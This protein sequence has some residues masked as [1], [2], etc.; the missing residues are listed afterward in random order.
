MRALALAL[1]LS[2]FSGPA[3]AQTCGG[4]FPAF[5]DQMR[6]EAR[7]RGHDQTTVDRF[8]RNVRRDPDV[9]AADKRQGHFQRDFIDFSGRLIAQY[10]VDN[11][12]YYANQLD[13][14]FDRIEARYGVS[15]GV[16]LAFWAFETDFG[17]VQ[18]DYNTRDA[19]VT[20][21]HDCR[22][23]E[24]FRPHVF[25]ALELFARG[26]FDP[27]NT[28]GAWAGEIGQVQ[29]LPE[30][31]LTN[32]VDGD[33]DGRV[34][35][36]TSSADALMSGAAMLSDLGWRPDEPWLQ[37]IRVPDTLDW[38]LTGLDQPR[39][40]SDWA[41]MGVT[42]RA[43]NLRGDLDAAVLLPMGRNGPAF[44]AYPNF[45]VYFEWN[46]SFVYVLTAA[47]FANILEGAPR[48]DPR[49]PEPGLS[50]PDI[51]ALQEKLVARGYDVGGIDGIIG[52]MTRDAVQEEQI[53]LGMPADAW[54]TSALL[55]AL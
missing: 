43:G 22:R 34:T 48:F 13:S 27:A 11:G 39:P 18:G 52:A 31:I 26:D 40:T 46:K 32:G 53:R 12:T 45:N 25:A 47:H 8:F 23:P 55:K 49:N 3:L 37:E 35:L 4:S 24:L 5:V 21:A 20:L 15:R 2:L 17:Q 19:L 30:D 54:P 14:L 38:S 10:R 50:G 41:A 42:A 16:L 1:A 44:L 51:L 33:G 7:D 36:K 6:A 28:T 9:I 29:M